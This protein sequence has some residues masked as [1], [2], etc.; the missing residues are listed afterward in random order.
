MTLV[1]PEYAEHDDCSSWLI[2]S[3]DSAPRQM[4]W[5]TLLLPSTTT[6]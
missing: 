6:Q 1:G 2:E 5:M 4:T 3:A